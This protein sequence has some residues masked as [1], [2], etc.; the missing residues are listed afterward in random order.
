LK[1]EKGTDMYNDHENNIIDYS[2]EFPDAI[3]AQGSGRDFLVLYRLKDPV[4]RFDGK[5][6]I[7][8]IQY[9]WLSQECKYDTDE[10]WACVLGEEYSYWQRKEISNLIRKIEQGAEVNIFDHFDLT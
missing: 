7:Y 2:H 9:R 3:L 5:T 4:K 1:L 10:S 6:A 8:E